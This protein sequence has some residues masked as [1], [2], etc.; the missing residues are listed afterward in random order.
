MWVMVRYDDEKYLGKVVEKGELDCRVR[1]LHISMGL[2]VPSELE[3][4]EMFFTGKCTKQT[5]SQT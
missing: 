1:C 2:N 3:Q 5:F 4:E